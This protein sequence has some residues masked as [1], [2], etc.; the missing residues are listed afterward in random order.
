[1]RWVTDALTVAKDVAV[2][3]KRSLTAPN[4]WA[5]QIRMRD[6][7]PTDPRKLSLPEVTKEWEREATAVG[8]W[9]ER[10][11]NSAMSEQDRKQ[12]ISTP[13]FDAIGKKITAICKRIPGAEPRELRRLLLGNADLELELASLINQKEALGRKIAALELIVK[14]L[15]RQDWPFNG[16]TDV[17]ANKCLNPHPLDEDSV[18]RLASDL[19]KQ[20][21]AIRGSGINKSKDG[22]LQKVKAVTNI[23]LSIEEYLANR[24]LSEEER[25]QRSDPKPEP[26]D[27]DGDDDAG[28]LDQ[29]VH[30]FPQ[31]ATR[32]AVDL[33]K[34]AFPTAASNLTVSR[35]RGRRARGK[36]GLRIRTPHTRRP[37]ANL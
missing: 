22:P 8:E 18:R 13:R 12:P 35:L 23:A 16:E 17:D 32:Y 29:R 25:R 4:S 6:R 28:K 31:L 19:R 26:S 14:A 2:R 33:V 7:G 15:E 36:S 30:G 1:M 34:A 21:K 24:L 27:D 20:S 37:S 3:P 11:R 9:L 5:N 10:Q